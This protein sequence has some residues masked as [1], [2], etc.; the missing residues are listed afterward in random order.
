ML[1]VRPMD[2]IEGGLGTRAE[3]T[4]DVADWAADQAPT[5]G[6]RALHREKDDASTAP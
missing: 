1:G 4:G 5:R 3:V 2:G 6:R